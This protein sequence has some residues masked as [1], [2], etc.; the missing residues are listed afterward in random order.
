MKSNSKHFW[1][2]R[3]HKVLDDYESNPLLQPKL[4]WKVI[5]KAS[6]V[7]R[8]KLWL[9][10]LIYERY[11]SIKKLDRNSDYHQSSKRR[12]DIQRIRKLE[13]EIDDLDK[14]LS[15]L[16]E[17]FIVLYNHLESLNIDPEKLLRELKLL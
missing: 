9:D 14:S 12:T 5:A 6:G 10:K 8:K 17:K 1:Q 15:S 3:A 11:S 13:V 2:E 16:Q 4:T 7:G